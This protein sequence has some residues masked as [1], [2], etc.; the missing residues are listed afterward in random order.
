MAQRNVRHTSAAVEEPWQLTLAVRSLLTCSSNTDIEPKVG[1]LEVYWA[2][3][4]GF[5]NGIISMSVF[6]WKQWL[7]GQCFCC[8]ACV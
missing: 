8:A 7:N 1:G 2:L 3:S 4:F 6:Q 5:C